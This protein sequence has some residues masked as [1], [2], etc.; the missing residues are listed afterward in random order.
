MTITKAESRVVRFDSPDLIDMGSKEPRRSEFV[1]LELE[2]DEG[3]RG[4]GLTF[5]GGPLNRVQKE[6]IDALA[7]MIIGEDPMH[8][9]A[10][11]S[12]LLRATGAGPGGMVM[13]AV[14]AIDIALWDIKG[15]ALG[16]PVCTLLGGYRDRAPTYASGVLMRHEPL[17]FLEEAGPKLIERG[18]RQMKTFLGTEPTAAR[19]VERIRVIR[20]AI[21]YDV[22]LMCDIGQYWDV[23]QAIQI[24][25]MLEPYQLSWL[26]DIVMHDDYQGMARVA[27][28]LS[29]PICAG[30]LHYGVTPFRQMLE[31]KS[32]DIAMIDLFRV[33]GV[34]QWRKVAA[35]AET[36]NI[37]VVSH[38]VPEIHVHLIAAVPNGLTVEFMPWSLGLYEEMPVVENGQIVVP[39]NPGFGLTFREDLEVIG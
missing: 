36:F 11:S 13:L 22:E 34:T 14:S 33:G 23:G 12:K 18:F 37:P 29:T 38:L 32:I 39:K 3:I 30:E 1:I 9:E 17:E 10:L 24:G 25:R 6:T 8:V 35:L 4:I 15:K 7:A 19:E 27:R 20:E 2:T 21:G 28:A 5:F 31:H 26:E 16:L